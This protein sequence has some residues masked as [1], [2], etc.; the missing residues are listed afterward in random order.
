MK[1]RTTN[2]TAQQRVFDAI[3]QNAAGATHD[4]IVA[5]TGL[6]TQSVRNAL[7]A[8]RRHVPIETCTPRTLYRVPPGT[9]RPQDGRGRKCQ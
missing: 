7:Y 8:L 6:P 2:G 4:Q 1:P 9:P 3:T 5:L